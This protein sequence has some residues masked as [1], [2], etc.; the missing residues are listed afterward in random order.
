MKPLIVS[1]TLLCLFLVSSTVWADAKEDAAFTQQVRP[2]LAKY[3]FECHS[4]PKAK[5]D[6]HLDTLSLDFTELKAGAVWKEVDELLAAGTMPPRHKPQPSGGGSQDGRPLARGPAGDR[7]RGPAEGGRPGGA[8]AA[9]SRRVRQHPAQPAG[10]LRRSQGPAARGRGGGRLRQYRVGPRHLARADGTLP[11]SRGRGPQ[12]RHREGSEAGND[13]AVASLSRTKRASPSGSH[14]KAGTSGKD[15][16]VVLLTEA[17][18]G[19]RHSPGFRGRYRFRISAQADNDR[20][21]RC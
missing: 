19:L 7:R 5:G 14:G 9:Q 2:I 12:C 15:D 21:G 6:L 20:A 4:G 3:C 8:A 11:G 10:H 13:Q 18:T 16:G 1:I 17:P